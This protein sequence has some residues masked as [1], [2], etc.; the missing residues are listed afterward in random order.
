MFGIPVCQPAFVYGDNQAVLKNTSIPESTLNKKSN[1]I[2]YHF[3]REGVA[4]GEWIT[5]YILSE[6]NSADTQ[7][8]T[9]PAGAKQNGLVSN[10]LYDIYDDDDP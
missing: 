5:G 3:V 4:R 9:V 10:Y 1:S 7:T 8:K 6:D 2:A